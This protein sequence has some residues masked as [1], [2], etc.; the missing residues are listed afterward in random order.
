VAGFLMFSDMIG[1]K[2]P[3]FDIFLPYYLARVKYDR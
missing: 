2:N 1:S 3:P